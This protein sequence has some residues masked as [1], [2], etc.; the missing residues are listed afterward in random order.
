M[1][2]AQVTAV[3][4]MHLTPA[5]LHEVECFQVEC[6]AKSTGGCTS[7]GIHRQHQQILRDTKTG[8]ERLHCV[9]CLGPRPNRETKA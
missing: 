4:T 5:E 8:A 6:I 7:P 2:E 3:S 9:V 1:T